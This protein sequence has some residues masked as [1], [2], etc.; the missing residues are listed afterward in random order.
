MD[1][2]QDKKALKELKRQKKER[3]ALPLVD[4]KQA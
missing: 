2:V 1:E 4:P 3:K